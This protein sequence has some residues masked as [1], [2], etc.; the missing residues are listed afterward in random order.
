MGK[1]IG[2]AFKWSS[3]CNKL[4]DKKKDSHSIAWGSWSIYSK[5]CTTSVPWI[6]VLLNREL[7]RT[8]VLEV[9]MKRRIFFPDGIKILFVHCSVCFDT[10]I[11]GEYCRQTRVSSTEICCVRCSGLNLFWEKYR[12][13]L[14]SIRHKLSNSLPNLLNSLHNIYVYMVIAFFPFLNRLLLEE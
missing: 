10:P 9:W 6:L 3:T 4:N 11:A 8:T 2:K 12:K 14:S 13:Y 5:L 1:S 7:Y